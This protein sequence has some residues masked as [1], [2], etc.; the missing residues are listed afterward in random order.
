M[1]KYT[2]SPDVIATNLGHEMI[3]LDPRDAGM[4]GLNAGGRRVWLDLP[5]CSVAQLADTLC[6][7]FQVVPERARNDVESLVAALVDAGL[8]VHEDAEPA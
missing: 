8:V 6:S 4:L 3:L 5:A 2:C 1:S 7:A